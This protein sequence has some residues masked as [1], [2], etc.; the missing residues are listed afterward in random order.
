MDEAYEEF[1]CLISDGAS[2]TPGTRQVAAEEPLTIYVDGEP[3]VVLVRT[4]GHDRELALGYLLTEGLVD[5]ARDVA[6]PDA[7]RGR[8]GRLHVELAPGVALGC[9]AVGAPKVWPVC[10][11]CGARA[12]ETLV[13][14]MPPFPGTAIAAADLH[15][16]ARLLRAQQP[17]FEATGGT[18]AAAL[19]V[20][21]PLLPDPTVIVREDIGRCNSVD[22]VIGACHLAEQAL[23]QPLLFVS[24]RCSFETVAK[25]ARAG[26]GAVAGIGAPTTM[27]VKLARRLNMFLAGF[28]RGEAFTV[29]SGRVAGE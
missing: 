28:V 19:C 2:L 12:I 22:K 26:V 3:L 7:D 17:L 1:D 27:A 29:Y 16:M 6:F 23:D 21:T 4:P 24:G 11:L 5:S 25:A 18:H 13:F 8:E 20:K 15:E 9:S 10:G 14:E